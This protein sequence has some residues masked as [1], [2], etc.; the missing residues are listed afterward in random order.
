M[1]RLYLAAF[2]SKRL[3]LLETPDSSFDLKYARE[4]WRRD[5]VRAG[6]HWTGRVVSINIYNSQQ[7]AS[8]GQPRNWGEIRD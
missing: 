1:S 8:V 7:T 3:F 2:V 5:D 4:A 6:H